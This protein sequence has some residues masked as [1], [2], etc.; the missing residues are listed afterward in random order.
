M[1]QEM[2]EVEEGRNC[3]L[4]ISVMVII[5]L[6]IFIARKGGKRPSSDL[7]PD[8]GYEQTTASSPL[9]Y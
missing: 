8:V 5:M 3:F 1:Y 6:I 2:R 4:T 7:T 9:S